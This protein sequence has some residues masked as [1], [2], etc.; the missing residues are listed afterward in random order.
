MSSKDQSIFLAALMLGVTLLEGGNRKVQDLLASALAQVSSQPCFSQ[1]LCVIRDSIGALKKQKRR[2]KGQLSKGHVGR[3]NARVE[4]DSMPSLGASIDCLTE[5]I[6]IIR[7]MCAGQHRQLQNIVRS[8]RLNKVSVNFLEEIVTFLVALE[9]ELMGA[10]RSGDQLV[11]EGA[12]QGFLMLS[13][14]M[15]G[16]NHENQ[17]SVA[18]TGLCDLGDRIFGKI[19]FEDPRKAASKCTDQESSQKAINQALWR[20][21]ARSRLKKS[22]TGCLLAFLEGVESEAIPTQMLTTVQWSAV[23]ARMSECFQALQEGHNILEY[24]MLFDEGI[25]YYFV[26]RFLQVYDRKKQFIEPVLSKNRKAAAFFEQCTGFVEIVRDHRLERVLFALPEQCL[27]GGPLVN[28]TFR[29]E[30]HDKCDLDDADHKNHQWVAN[31][32]RIIERE[33]HLDSVRST[34]LAFTVTRWEFICQATFWVALLIH[35]I[36]VC[37][38]YVPVWRRK[39]WADHLIA[40]DKLGMRTA[41]DHWFEEHARAKFES[42]SSAFTVLLFFFCLVRTFSFAWAEIPT[43]I[44]LGLQDYPQH[45]DLE[46]GEDEKSQAEE[47]TTQWAEEENVFAPMRHIS[48]LEIREAQR[49]KNT[50][51]KSSVTHHLWSKRPHMPHMPHWHNSSCNGKHEVRISEPYSQNILAADMLLRNIP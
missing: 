48:D 9:P 43:M 36:L 34:W 29:Q 47:G 38:S 40:D 6:K 11:V 14:A 46:K 7:S 13:D 33:I 5:V 28:K 35:A 50:K 44:S 16:P 51:N 26:L 42:A 21:R 24:S 12:I 1:M 2:V 22:V 25:S 20:N 4:N 23:A 3:E 39:Q 41:N 49:A 27:H 8:Q 10:I 30:M 32:V 18:Q 17:A 15:R 45:S 19:D 37:G 31:M